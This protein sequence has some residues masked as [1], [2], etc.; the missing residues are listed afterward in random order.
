LS[1]IGGMEGLVA[2]G[3]QGNTHNSIAGHR[4]RQSWPGKSE[5]WEH[6]RVLQHGRQAKALISSA[7]LLASALSLGMIVSHGSKLTLV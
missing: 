2:I 5:Q 7:E 3:S 6:A 1:W 4:I